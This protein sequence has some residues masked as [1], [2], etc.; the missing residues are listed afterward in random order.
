MSTPEDKILLA[1]CK[2]L[3]SKQAFFFRVNNLPVF[4]KKLNNGYGAYRGMGAYALKG[5]GDILLVDCYGTL[6]M[7]EAKTP[8]G[9]LS[10]DQLLVKKR[11]ERHNAHYHVVRSVEDAKALDIVFH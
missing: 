7:I 4:D 10:P 9:R 6:H 2:Y 8:T 1:V 5:I 3:A 11:C